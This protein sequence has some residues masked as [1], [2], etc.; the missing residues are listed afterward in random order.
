MCAMGPCR[1]VGKTTEGSAALPAPRSRPATLRGPWRP[2][3][4]RTPTMA[5]AW[6]SPCWR[7][8]RARPQGYRI[9]DEVKLRA[10]AGYLGIKSEGRHV[11]EI[12]L[13]VAE[14]ALAEFGQTDRGAHLRG[15]GH[16]APPGAVAA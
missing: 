6:P 9:R 7:S 2:A 3:Q 13:D 4:P 10:V 11:N 15:P 14:T 16:T 12:A 1:L 8:P 5:A